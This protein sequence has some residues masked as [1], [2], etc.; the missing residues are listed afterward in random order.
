MAT[1]SVRDLE[2][3]I[4]VSKFAAASP[5]EERGVSRDKVKMLVID[6]ALGNFKH[7]QFQS[8]PDFFE[9]GDVVIVNTSM[10]I[11]AR[12]LA[13]S[14]GQMH[15]IHLAARFSAT[16][17]MIERRDEFGEADS[18][19]WEAEEII[20]IV[21]SGASGFTDEQFPGHLKV[22]RRF[23]P[24]SRLWEVESNVDLYQLAQTIGCP[25]RYSYVKQ[26]TKTSDYATIFGRVPGSAEM[27]SASR[28]FT[29]GILRRLAARGVKVVSITL[30]TSV[31]SHEVERDLSSHPVLPEWF[32]VSPQAASVINEAKAGGHRLV[33]VGT[34]AVRAVESA[35]D[36]SGRVQPKEGWTTRIITPSSPPQVITSLV[37]GMHDNHSSHLALMYAFISP[38]LLRRAYHQAADAGYLW[39]EFGDMSL[40]L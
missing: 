23:H 1:L 19:A 31:S 22:I 26:E 39:H 18:Q 11:P 2:F 35:V 33:A 28:P 7:T 4:D 40:V 32:S 36:Q 30:H 34:T 15:I 5:A 8:I 14:Q 25:I 13:K 20:D 37:T 16:R 9:P 3:G 38:A 17:F 29:K 27:P 24:N 6:R 10:T 12:L 21:Q